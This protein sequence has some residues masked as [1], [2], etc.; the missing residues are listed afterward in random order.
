MYR[1]GDWVSFA[2][3]LPM[4]HEP[5]VHWAYNSTSLILLSEIIT[6]ATRLSVPLFADKYLMKPLDITDF[7]WGFYPRG[8]PGWGGMPPCGP[9]TWPSSGR[10]A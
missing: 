9:G 5:G 4:A 8:E 7:R 1:T 3:N 6:Q 2:L 10:C